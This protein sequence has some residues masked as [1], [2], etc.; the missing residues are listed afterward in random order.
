MYALHLA[1]SAIR[2]GDCDGAIVA[3]ANWIQDPSMQIVLD[4]L[5]AL[6]PTSRCHTFDAAADGYARGEG[7]AAIYLKKSDLAV[8]EGTPIRAMIRGTGVNA[9]G[10]TGGITRP[11]AKGQEDAIRKAFENAGNLPLE[12]TTF[13]ECHGTGTPAGDPLEVAA[14]GNVF[15][16]S[17]KSDA[18]EDRLLIGSI[19]PNLGHTE[20]ASALA[21][22]M[23]VVLSLE[24]GEIAPTCGIEN[25][26]PHIDFDAAKI[27]VVKDAAIP[28]P[29]GKVRRAS[30]NS[31]GFGGANGNC[32]IDHVN[33]VLP[34]YVKPGIV[35]STRHV[36]GNLSNGHTNGAPSTN[37]N[38]H[39][40]GNGS[41]HGYKHMPVRAE[42]VQKTASSTASTRNFVLLPFSA[43]NT[44][45][46]DQNIDTLTKAVANKKQ[47]T[48]AD[49]AY[50]L[51]SKRSR[52]QQR[53]F[54]IVE[55]AQS[56]A[57]TAALAEEQR[58]FA[59]PLQTSNVAFVFTGQGA[60]WHAMG[61][62]L[63]EYGV[64]RSTISH[65]DYVLDQLRQDLGDPSS[66][67]I[68]ATLKG[69][70]EP[71]HI[72]S[73]HVSQ[74]ACTAIQIG[75]V[76]LLASWSVR[77]RAVAGHSSGEM[78]AAYAGGYLTA[79][80]AIAAAYFR[81][82]AVAKNKQI[83]AM[84]AVGLGADD[85]ASYLEGREDLVRVAAMNSPGSVTLSGDAEAV[86][87]VSKELSTQGIFNRVLKTSGSAYHS[88]HMVAVGSAYIDM[89]SRGQEVLKRLGLSGEAQR[90]P[91][92]PWAS[93]VKPDKAFS[94]GADLGGPHY[95][96]ENLES[97]VRFTQA[98]TKLMTLDDQAIDIL[99]EVGPHG[100][101]KGPIEQ[102][103][104]GIGKPAHYATALTRNEDGRRALLQLA[105]TL[106][107]TN[108]DIDLAAVNSV[109][110]NDANGRPFFVHGTVAVDLPTYQ[111][112]YGPVSYY[113]SRMSKEFRLRE[114]I[115][116]D[117]LGSDVLGASKL[118]PQWRNVLRVKD[119][120]WLADH[121]LVPDAV[122][123]AAGY[124][125]LGV[126][127]ATRA[128]QSLPDSREITGYKFQNVD[129]EATLTIPEDDYGVEIIIGAELVDKTTADEPA[130]LKFTVTSV[131]RAS[132]EWTQ[133]CTGLA[134]VEVASAVS[135]AQLSAEMDPR[136]PSIAAWYDKFTSVGLGYGKTFQP[137]S[138]L[139]VDPHR[140][141]AQA[142]VALNST[143]GSVEGGESSYPL[144]PAA[145]DATFQLAIIAIYGGQL[146]RATA[147]F[148]PVQISQL[149]LKAGVRQDVHVTAIAH[150]SPQ[151]LR[152]ATSEL[153]LVDEGGKV[154]LDVESMRFT[155]FRETKSHELSSQQPFSSP[156]TRLAWKPD[157]R[158][159]ANDRLRE[160]F[161]PPAENTDLA[162][163]LEIL[164]MI[165]VLVAFDIYDL[166]VAGSKEKVS[167]KGD[168]RH[169]LAWIK[170]LVEE[171]DP[172]SQVVEAKKLSAQE[173]RKRLEEL[174]P[175]VGD[176]P[177]AK[178]AR[179]LHENAA[180]ILNE[181]RTGIDVLISNKLL[182]PL[183]EVGTAIAGSHPQVSNVMDLLA[184]A[185]P[186]ARILEIGAGT[187][188]ATRAA[189]RVLVGANGIKRFADY[190]FTD[191]S[192][193][194][195]ASAKEMLS[196]VRDVHYSVLDVEQDPMEHGYEPVYDVVLACEAIHATES[197]D[198][199]LAHCRS[200]LRPGGKLVLVETTRMRVLLGLLYGTLTGYWQSDGRTE[201]PFMSLETWQ[202][203]LTSTGFSGVD[204]HVD[205][206]E[207][208]HNTT[209]VLVTTRLADDEKID[210][211]PAV[212]S[213][214]EEIHLL[215]DGDAT[216]ALLKQ[217]SFQR[218]YIP[219]DNH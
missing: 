7:F 216:P 141:L 110:V 40:N 192:A 114:H 12:D 85:V 191:I 94:H 30:V 77:P 139:Q 130:W 65:L 122:F 133:H 168:I 49:I 145:L 137:L 16:S 17:R 117:L 83:G 215:H 82:Q 134:K 80:E 154:F 209:S 46:L 142:K 170:R 148:V 135:R 70:C 207:A 53:T 50:T 198:R 73:P 51:G 109:D 27:H 214:G 204:L 79:A 132:S 167:P 166:F 84:L 146:E 32:I 52:F 147:A 131:S 105:G 173:R 107:A 195:L 126:E 41:T 162:E 74:V 164:E 55:T 58:V 152:G 45:S 8:L 112:S 38:G 98:L 120:P 153:Q 10:K 37:G 155:E 5:G 101:L 28:W 102:T 63:F 97:P 124:I 156:F 184:H 212:R 69:D 179:L 3:A 90:Y 6:S 205:D 2:S 190:T 33:E 24:A 59:S 185:N 39:V 175:K 181:R 200:L 92:V 219:L 128:Y 171:E 19:K 211:K 62:Q 157:I 143:A 78:G 160:V 213:A 93:S 187:G 103:L 88:H 149:Y 129:I 197:M 56:D 67:T 206:Y 47:W 4:K 125:A 150:S 76:D 161:P 174:Y 127:A 22:I 15:A 26:N 158:S 11:S 36:N 42:L 43:H 34:G 25:L 72:Q 57:V 163:A 21:S 189:M 176:R 183:Y 169:W 61:G 64:F 193:G 186:N 178:A 104:K 100:A 165:C 108:A 60:Q 18:P 86:D 172:R 113:E 48:L 208:P 203:R 144:H 188:A 177:E 35:N 115:R 54:R 210:S 194:F 95:W 66:W 81:G 151:G 121:R 180:E 123:P 29:E 196:H 13:F 20:G 118:Q 9:N 96:R 140:G 159:I 202:R 68:A 199:T 182:T 138:D 136:Y 218:A 201:G 71:E 14:V 44:S 116:H 89:L 111:Y 119:I 99:V 31:F 91:K 1:V 106:Y 23:K 75:L 87:A 217:V